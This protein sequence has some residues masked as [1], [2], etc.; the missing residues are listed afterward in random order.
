[1]TIDKPDL[2][3][4]VSAEYVKNNNIKIV[5]VFVRDPIKRVLSGLSTQ[6]KILQIP[7]HVIEDIL[8]QQE[9]FYFYDAHTAPQFWFLLRIAQVLDVKFQI[10]LLSDIQYVDIDVPHKN[11]NFNTVIN[12]TNPATIEKLIHFYTEDIVLYNQFLN[13]ICSI[14]SIIEKIKLEKDFVND[15]QQYRSILTYLL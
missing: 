5:T 1:L 8:N 9:H 7:K 12:L 13:T 6:S 10:K 15:L 4:V 11:V 3:K 14:D 2:F